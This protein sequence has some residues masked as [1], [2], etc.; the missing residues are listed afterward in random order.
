M[1]QPAFWLAARGSPPGRAPQAMGWFSARHC[2]A[3]LNRF[4]IVKIPEIVSNFKNS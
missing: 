3:I 4:S 2:V 1:D